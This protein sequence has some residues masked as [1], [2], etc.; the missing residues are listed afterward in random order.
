MRIRV[1]LRRLLLHRLLVTPLLDLQHKA[2][3]VVQVLIGQ[4]TLIAAKLGLAVK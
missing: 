1:V 2:I 4:L 3:K